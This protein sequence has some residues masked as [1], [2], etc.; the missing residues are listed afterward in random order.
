M[1]YFLILALLVLGG[2]AGE[3]TVPPSSEA[4]Q[5]VTLP[6]QLDEAHA[7]I[8]VTVNGRPARLLLDTGAD[9][10][11]LSAS[12]A[13]RLGLPVRSTGTPGSGAAG[14]Y[15]AST[16]AIADLGAGAIHRHELTAYVVP[17]P[18][19]FVYDGV[20]GTPFFATVLTTL[21][22]QQ[23]TVILRSHAPLEP[24]SDGVQMPMRIE[25]GKVLVLASAAG[26]TGWFCV[27]TGAG[28][29]LT[30]FTPVVKQYGLRDAFSPSVRTITGVSAGGYTRGTLVR[31]PDLTIGPFVLNQI[32]AELS[33]AEQGAFAS[34]QYAGNL[35]GELWSRFKVTFD[36]A[37]RQMSLTPND[38]LTQPFVGPRSGLAASLVDGV[39]KAVDV[40]TGSPAAEAGLNIGDVIVAMNGTGTDARQV[41]RALH[42]APGTR[43][44]LTVRDAPGVEREVALVLRD[45]L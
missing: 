21:D 20:L 30:F 13:Q 45:L 22:Y 34:A 39:I 14:T 40:V 41:T 27:D 23:R 18:E 3:P 33:E 35:G 19:E 12:A 38:A 8:E 44:R 24:S 25:S 42:A 32:V 43:V 7:S 15:I 31:V 1:R 26:V 17:F 11:V 6:M 29:A 10:I 2:C 36:Y 28:N 37:S 16:T 5:V 4:A 9:Q